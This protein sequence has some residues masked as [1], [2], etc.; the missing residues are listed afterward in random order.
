LRQL[1]NAKG[2]VTE[3]KIAIISLGFLLKNSDTFACFIVCVTPGTQT[4]SFA[5]LAPDQGTVHGLEGI[6]SSTKPIK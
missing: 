6:S 5:T 2:F 3:T 1:Y 4:V